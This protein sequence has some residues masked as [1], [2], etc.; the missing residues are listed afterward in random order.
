MNDKSEIR[1][2]I[3]HT[4]EILRGLDKFRHP[5]AQQYIDKFE[6]LLA[7]GGVDA[8]A[9]Y[10]TCS[11]SMAGD[12]CSQW[13]KYADSGRG[14]ALEFDGLLL[15]QVY[16][17]HLD[18]TLLVNNSTFPVT[19]SDIKLRDLITKIIES[20]PLPLSVP[21]ENILSSEQIHRYT[22]KLWA[23]LAMHLLRCSLFSNTKNISPRK[24]I[25]F[26]NYFGLINRHRR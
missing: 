5:G 12:K 11:F 13:H 21:H 24:N 22:C 18:G 9:H 6:T 20:V 19:Y 16:T 2:G 23:I 8:V 25:D 1:H 4:V 26:S 14:F 15:E 7:L 10:F 17:K 3:K